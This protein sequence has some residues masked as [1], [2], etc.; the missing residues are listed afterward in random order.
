MSDGPQAGGG[1][2]GSELRLRIVSGAVLAAVAIATGWWGGVALALFWLAAAIG[3]FVEWW[4]L[5]GPRPIWRAI[6][7]FYAA[8]V[9]LPPLML[10]ADPV[11]GFAALAWLF[12]VVWGSDVM[13]YVFGRSIGGPKLAPR[14]SPKKTWS[15]FLGGT[16]S[17]S[18]LGTVVAAAAALPSL[19]PIFLLSFIVAVATQAGDLFE[20]GMKRRFGVKDA[21]TLIPGHG[22]LMD[23]LDGFIIAGA[24]AL[25][26]G[27]ARGG[28]ANAGQ[29]LLLW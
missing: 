7:V 13:A 10:R 29:G 26:I 19:L 5:V 27:S 22:G 28:F 1:R 15:G 23:R 14:L 3:V 25:L 12:A 6:G 18:V 17:A 11:L 20:S 16:L 9:F 4:R 2:P 21:G 24:L 8:A